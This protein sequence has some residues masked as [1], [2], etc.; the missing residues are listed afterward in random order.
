MTRSFCAACHNGGSNEVGVLHNNDDVMVHSVLFEQLASYTQDRPLDYITYL[1]I[2]CKS[3]ITFDRRISGPS[4]R[5]VIMQRYY[6]MGH[7]D[8]Q[9][10]ILIF[11]ISFMQEWEYKL[12][13]FIVSFYSVV[14]LRFIMALL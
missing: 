8:V 9:A 10:Y 7:I 4:S 11:N 1:F 13:G 5:P 2:A 3:T 14:I 6:Y 12:Q